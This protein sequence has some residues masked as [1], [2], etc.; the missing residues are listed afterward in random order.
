MLFRRGEE[1]IPRLD[2]LSAL[3]IEQPLT[4]REPPGRGPGLAVQ[5]VEEADP[6]CA[7]GGARTVTRDPVCPVSAL[8]RPLELTLA[9]QQERRG[10]QPLEISRREGD[11]A[12]G[13]GQELVGVLP[14]AAVVRSPAAIQVLPRHIISM[15]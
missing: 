11:L 12:V 5:E 13:Q 3:L 4:V 6:E 1:E 8:Q 15:N 10:R 7:A 9:S 2:G 14:R